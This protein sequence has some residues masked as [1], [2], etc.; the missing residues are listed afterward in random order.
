MPASAPDGRSVTASLAQYGV[1][2]QGYFLCRA[3]RL[4]HEGAVDPVMN[5]GDWR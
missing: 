5:R 2:R 1:D 3:S 4:E